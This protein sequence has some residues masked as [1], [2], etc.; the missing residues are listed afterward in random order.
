MLKKRKI[1]SPPACMHCMVVSL[2]T[3]E[4]TAAQVAEARTGAAA[5]T[6]AQ[7]G[8]CSWLDSYI[9]KW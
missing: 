7:G 2:F 5:I 3:A 9:I 6:L 4:T 8:V 1:Q